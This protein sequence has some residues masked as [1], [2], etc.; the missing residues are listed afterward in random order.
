MPAA[1][2]DERD[3][4]KGKL[5][6]GTRITSGRDACDVATTHAETGGIFGDEVLMNCIYR[7]MRMRL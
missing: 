7:F 3:H 4:P 2:A 1:D 5:A 6:G